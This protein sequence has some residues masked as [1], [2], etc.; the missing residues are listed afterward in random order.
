[1]LLTAQKSQTCEVRN[2]RMSKIWLA[3]VRM[4]IFSFTSSQK[5]TCWEIIGC[6]LPEA[7]L[8]IIVSQTSHPYF[9]QKTNIILGLCFYSPPHSANM[10]NKNKGHVRKSLPK[11]NVTFDATLWC[12]QQKL[13]HTAFTRWKHF[14]AYVF[15]LN[16][17]GT[18]SPNWSFSTN[19]SHWNRRENFL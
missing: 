1:M 2:N 9:A 10:K 19:N 16:I 5:L 8:Q 6:R 14:K 17:M 15:T 11:S 18:W 3:P 7:Y 13:I 4:S 12:E